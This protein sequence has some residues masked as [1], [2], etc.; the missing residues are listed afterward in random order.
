MSDNSINEKKTRKT[1]GMAVATAIVMVGL[2]FS[3]MSSFL[4]EVF[5]GIKFAPVYRDAFILAFTIP[6]IVFNLLVGGA[7]QSAITPTMSSYISKGKEKEGWR[8]VNIFISVLA[9]VLIVFIVAGVLFSDEL[10]VFFFAKNKGIYTCQLAGMASKW[11]FPQIFFMMLAALC[12]GILNSYKRFGSTA[13]GPT[14]YSIF[15]LASI[16]FFA[17]NTPGQLTMTTAGV[18]GAT[19]IYFLFQFII[20][21]DKLKYFRF[22]FKPAD[23]E[24]LLLLRKALPILFSASVVQVNLA[25]IRKFTLEFADSTDGNIYL[26]NNATTIWQLPYGIFAVGLGNVMLPSLAALY[27]QKK[28]GEC[29]DL[30]SSRLRSALFLTVPS[31]GF[32]LLMNTDVMKAAFQWGS[33]YTDE[34]ARIAGLFLI[35]Y[36]IAIVTHSIVFIMNQA[37]YAIGKTKIPLIAGSICLITNPLM[38]MYFRD[39]GMSL[40]WLTI[41]YSIT[42]T[43]QMIVLCLLSRKY[44]EIKPHSMPSFFI[45]TAVCVSVMCAALWVLDMFFPGQ[46]NKISQ[47]TILAGKGIACVVIYFVLALVLKMPEATEWIGKFRSKIG[48]AR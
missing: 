23:P 32:L 41:S 37:Y 6:D 33:G 15:V 4:R 27:G 5:I 21:F 26:L 17:G 25:I 29:S 1:Y 38:C 36:C 3:K 44:K 8:V 13:F 30:L 46:G 35:G 39:H 43:I 34:D 19:V 10:Y 7:I 22:D 24:F 42:S 16:Y 48:R 28:T 20:G 18:L 14:I 45:K 40:I 12:I 9:V 11:L 2:V 31:S 47:L